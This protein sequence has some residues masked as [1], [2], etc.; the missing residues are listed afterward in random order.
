MLKVKKITVGAVN[1]MVGSFFCPPL[2]S[3]FSRGITAPAVKGA[4]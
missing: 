3:K 4:G 2:L 1:K